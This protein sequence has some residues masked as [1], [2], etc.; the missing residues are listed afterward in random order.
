[1]RRIRRLFER[2]L[3]R[4][5]RPTHTIGHDGLT[6]CEGGCS[7]H[8]YCDMLAVA[9]RGQYTAMFPG[10]TRDGKPVVA[11]R[12]GYLAPA[13]LAYATDER[14]PI[15]AAFAVGLFATARPGIEA[16]GVLP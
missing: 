4:R 7:G 9:E 3:R 12:H 10:H 16:E 8:V 11:F 5:T 14:D 6:G 15:R 1:M 2:L 13:Q